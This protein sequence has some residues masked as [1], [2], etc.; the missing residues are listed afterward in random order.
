M[1]AKAILYII[2]TIAVI[3]S[4]E[5]ININ[6]IFKK[7]R[8]IQARVFYFLLALAIIYPVTNFLWDF[9]LATKI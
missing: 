7:N 8:V 1:N 6:Q 5:S 4:L 9:F 2:V 3:W